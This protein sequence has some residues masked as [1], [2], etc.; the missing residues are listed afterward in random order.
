MSWFVY[1]NKLKG[2]FRGCYLAFVNKVTQPIFGTTE[3]LAKINFSLFDYLQLAGFFYGRYIIP[4]IFIFISLILVYH[5]RK[6]LKNDQIRGLPY[7]FILYFI[8]LIIQIIL[9]F[10]PLIVHQPDRIANL[11]FV[12]Y[13]QI[14]LFSISLYLIFFQKN[15]SFSRILQVSLILTF[16]W[17]LSLFGC[18]D[19]PNVC[20]TNSALTYNEVYG[21]DWFYQLKGDSVVS[22][23]LSQLDRFHDLF[24]NPE[25]RDKLNYLP[26]HLGYSNGYD[27]FGDVNSGTGV[28]SYVVILTVDELL[29]QKVKGYT[30]MGRYTDSDFTRFRRDI[31]ANKIYDST[32][33]E[34]F[35][36][37]TISHSQRTL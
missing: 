33:I 2:D 36:S 28:L 35:K 26:D 1:N 3:K 9:L 13:I 20:K 4:T 15:I 32:N 17:S 29:Y 11:N 5:N 22:V 6:L 12:V 23:P 25:K 31:S 8:F 19:S 7:L 10:N 18:F 30:H 16:I 14:L 21:M 24:G 37:S 34:I 27:L